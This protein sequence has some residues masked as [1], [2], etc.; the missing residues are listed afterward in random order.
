MLTLRGLAY[1]AGYLSNC[2]LLLDYNGN[3]RYDRGEPFNTT[4][5]LA[6]GAPGHWELRVS[7]S[8]LARH[9]SDDGTPPLLTL[10][11]DGNNNGGGGD[12]DGEALPGG[13]GEQCRDTGTAE[14]PRLQLY[15]PLP[16]DATRRV[17]VSALSSLFAHLGSDVSEANAASIVSRALALPHGVERLQS[18]DPLRA[19]GRSAEGALVL[20]GAAHV[21]HTVAV[22]APG[23]A[24]LVH[25]SGDAHHEQRVAR[26]LFMSIAAKMAAEQPTEASEAVEARAYAFGSVE[27]VSDL[28]R[29][30]AAM[31]ATEHAHQWDEAADE[32]LLPIV[33]IVTAISDLVDSSIAN[34]GTQPVQLLARLEAI[35]RV[36]LGGGGGEGGGGA[37]EG[38]AACVAARG[39]SAQ[40]TELFASLCE[41]LFTGD[42]LI[43]RVGV[44][45]K[46][47]AAEI[48]GCTYKA[49]ANF[50]SNATF[51]DGSCDLDTR[52]SSSG[53]GGGG[54][55]GAATALVV[56]LVLGGLVALFF[57][58]R[59]GHLA[60]WCHLW[61]QRWRRMKTG[62]DLALP[63]YERHGATDAP[64][65]LVSPPPGT[66]TLTPAVQASNEFFVAG[67][68]QPQPQPN[69]PYAPPPTGDSMTQPLSSAQ[70]S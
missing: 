6:S 35:S 44:A 59:G 58:Y 55:G 65:M 32:G 2:V 12:G 30:V 67:G 66:C 31:F 20:A 1:E 18:Y 26:H 22:L 68:V 7:K 5:T 3:G 40:K 25:A 60:R 34:L 49:A 37:E 56:V 36:V 52:R 42:E 57:A 50:Q 23:L 48:P 69:E 15:S 11:V 28:G 27:E 29:G 9:R 19:M 24:A 64:R 53:G 38:A 39:A 43:A 8:S 45:K 21:L 63:G 17:A 41:P 51:D 33:R 16:V 47:E 13:A 10:L 70:L 54:G 14:R 46:E 61:C 62:D 4:S